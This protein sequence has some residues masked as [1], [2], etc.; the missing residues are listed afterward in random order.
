M[1]SYNVVSPPVSGWLEVSL[2]PEVIDYLW[3]IE[4]VSNTSVK[5]TLA[6]NITESKNLID[7]DDWFF[8]NVLLDCARNYKQEFPYTIKKPDT[9]RVITDKIE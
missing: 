5:N 9:K 4:R 8:K 2:D 1:F 3:E 6:G 7:K